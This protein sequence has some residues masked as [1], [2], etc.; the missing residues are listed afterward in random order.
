MSAMMRIG[1]GAASS[2]TNSQRERPAS[3]SIASSA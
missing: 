3:A 1:T 2:V